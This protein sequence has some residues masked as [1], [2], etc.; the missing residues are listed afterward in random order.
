MDIMTLE[1]SQWP[2]FYVRLARAEEETSCLGGEDK[3]KAEAILLAMGGF[4]VP[5]SLAY[6]ERRGGYCDCEILMNMR[7]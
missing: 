1:H 7:P 2:E 3:S 6:F 4:D 5:A